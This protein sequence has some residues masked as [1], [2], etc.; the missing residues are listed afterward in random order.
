MKEQEAIKESNEANTGSLEPRSNIS[1]LQNLAVIEVTGED[2]VRLLQGQVS[3]NI[4][5]MQKDEMQLAAMCNPKGRCISLFLLAKIELGYALFMAKDLVDACISNLKKYGVFYKVEIFEKT[6]NYAIYS[7]FEL[8][9][10][11]V[12]ADASADNRTEKFCAKVFSWRK[13]QLSL[14]LLDKKL[15]DQSVG[16]DLPVRDPR[17]V[18]NDSQWLYQLTLAQIPWLTQPVASHFLPHNLDLPELAAVDFKK[19]CF[20]GQE[21]I[22]RMQYKGKLK[23]HLQLFE[24][25]SEIQVKPGEFLYIEEKAVAEVISG[26]KGDNGCSAI[27]ALVRDKD[28]SSEKFRL[29]AQN[30]P[31]IR[32]TRK[33]K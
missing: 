7:G 20:T 27:L 16:H 33:I 4:E 6:D 26:A 2:A 28:L 5:S 30:G 10:D 18:G 23:S 21:V 31:I 12:L 19:G 3:V 32:L 25:D 13:K 24:T 11:D 9:L 8:S 1:L 15:L 17:R 14:I 29:Y 22:A